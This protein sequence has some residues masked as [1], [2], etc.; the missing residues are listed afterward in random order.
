MQS[1]VLPPRVARPTGC[2]APM[3]SSGCSGVPGTYATQEAA[4]G[5]PGTYA[6]QPERS[7][8]E[9]CRAPMQTGTYANE[10]VPGT[11]T[12]APGTIGD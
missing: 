9:R 1:W 6:S 4:N 7:L 3:R 8:T 12:R 11:S 5:V 2:R 10:E